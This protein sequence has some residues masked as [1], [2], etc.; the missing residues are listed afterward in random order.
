MGGGGGGMGSQNNGPY[1]NKKDVN[2]EI[3]RSVVVFF[4]PFLPAWRAEY[5]IV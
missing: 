4:L 1:G 5:P 2:R 3:L